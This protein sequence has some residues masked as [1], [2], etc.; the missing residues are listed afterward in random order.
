MASGVERPADEEYYE[1]AKPLRV[2]TLAQ[3]AVN[4]CQALHSV[5]WTK[6]SGLD[7]FES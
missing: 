2:D 3:L 1:R 5:D 6:I 7:G 4:C